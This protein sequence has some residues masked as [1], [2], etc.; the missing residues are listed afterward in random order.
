M[1]KF[2]VLRRVDAFVDYLAEV[3]ADNAKQAATIANNDEAKFAWKKSGIAHFDARSFVT[4][5]A[6]ERTASEKS[7]RHSKTLLRPRNY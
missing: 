2:Q 1:P 7:G 5:D 6:N 3:E 4:L